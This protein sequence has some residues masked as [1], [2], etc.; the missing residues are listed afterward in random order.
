MNRCYENLIIIDIGLFSL[1]FSLRLCGEKSLCLCGYRI[2][3]RST[4]TSSSSFE[5]S[6][7]T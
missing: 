2:M 5:D 1:S 4:I 7:Q 3:N 6:I